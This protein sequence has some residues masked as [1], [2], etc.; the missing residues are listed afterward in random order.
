MRFVSSFVSTVAAAALVSAA[1]VRHDNEQDFL[2]CLASNPSLNFVSSSSN[3]SQFTSLTAA[4][5]QRLS[6]S[7][8]AVVR[9]N[10]AQDVAAAV[11]CARNS[12]KPVTARGGGH[13]YAAYGVGNGNAKGL[14]VYLSNFQ[15]I[16]LA[17]D[18]FTVI[19]GGGTHLGDIA[20]QLDKWGLGLAHGVCPFVGVGG[21]AA[22][23]GFGYAS[24]AWGL[25]LDAITAFDVVLANGTYIAGL[26]RDQD[27]DLFWSLSGAAPN[28]GIV[29]AYHFLAH[30]KP[31]NA[32]RF[33]YDY[34]GASAE[35]MTQA[36][37]A[38]QQ[39][40]KS[41]SPPNLGITYAVHPEGSLE[42]SGVYYGSEDAFTQL[43]T[44]FEANLPSGAS[45]SINYTMSWIDSLQELAGSQAL[46]TQ[47]QNDY[48]DSFYAKS[49]M[50]PDSDQ[51][52]TE[53]AARAYFTYLRNTQTST[54]WFVEVNLYGGVGSAINAVSLDQSSF[55]HRSMLLT[56]QMYASSSTYSN[57][58]PEEGFS[59]VSGMYDALLNPMKDA[60]G[61]TYGSYVNYADP[62][63]SFD[64]VKTLYWGSQYDRLSAMRAKYDPTQVFMSPQA[65]QPY[66]QAKVNKLAE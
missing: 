26:T 32:V 45:K 20:V 51:L 66:D 21:H 31:D 7:A 65:I 1:P 53:D 38:Y 60:W 49:L 4:F 3:P 64:E 42:I 18:N 44:P 46:S 61:N 39:W 13:S 55:A 5:N 57:P 22:F 56:F 47:G 58:Y 2:S 30:R 35:T 17:Q 8:S 24:R 29:T 14:V 37:L 19:V 25:T 11:D 63:L 50:T 48:R 40:G 28:Y 27:P 36:F 62:A 15:N 52:I 16:T 34:S 43:M 9:P 6:S 23:G 33:K 10:D 41:S 12:N 54:M 59:F